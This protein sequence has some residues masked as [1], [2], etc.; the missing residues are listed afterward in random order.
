MSGSVVPARRK[1]AVGPPLLVS[2]LLCWFLEAEAGDCAGAEQAFQRSL[3]IRTRILGG[4]HPLV[5]QSRN[6]LAMLLCAQGRRVEGRCLLERALRMSE[7]ALGPTHPFV[8]QVRANLSALGE[9]ESGTRKPGAG[10]GAR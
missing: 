7:T 4:D 5:A 9:V 10:C 8:L 3:R 2:V 1:T 6:N